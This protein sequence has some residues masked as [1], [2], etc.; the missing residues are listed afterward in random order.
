MRAL[1]ADDSAVMRKVLASA[2][3]G[4]G[5]K[6]VDHVEDGQQAID[7]A[8][9]NEYAIILMDWDIPLVPGIDAVK[10]IR[11]NGCK[12]PV[13]VVMAEAEKSRVL[14]ALK[15]GAQKYILKPIDQAALVAKIKDIVD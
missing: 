12:A 7:Y 8:S 2:L 11:A 3:E 10:A 9:E 4:A 15:A 5:I 13:I 1:V 6:E 14:D